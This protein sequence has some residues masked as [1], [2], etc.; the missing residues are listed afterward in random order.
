[1]GYGCLIDSRIEFQCDIKNATNEY[2][3]YSE[4]SVY[5]LRNKRKFG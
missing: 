2:I 1:M 3:T 4:K 5:S